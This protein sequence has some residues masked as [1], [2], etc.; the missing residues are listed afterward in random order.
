MSIRSL[1]II[2][3]L[4]AMTVVTGCRTAP[5]HNIDNSP[6]TSAS[7][8]AVSMDQVRD[9]IVQSG[10]S[11]GWQMKDVKPGHV[12]GTLYLRSHMAQVDI[13]YNPKAYSIQY[14]NSSN[15]KYDGSTIH[16][17]YNGWVQRLDRTIQAHLVAL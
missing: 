3:L 9:A 10:A 6:V 17:N 2:A 4:A 5:V 8:N 15:L 1:A 14:K 7:G 13:F 16:S 11:L 12:V